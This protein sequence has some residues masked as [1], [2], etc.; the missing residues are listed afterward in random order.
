M[1]NCN[2]GHSTHTD[3]NH[4]CW[5]RGRGQS[6][7]GIWTWHG[8]RRGS[9]QTRSDEPRQT[10]RRT[11]ALVSWV[12]ATLRSIIFNSLS[13]HLME[14]QVVNGGRGVEDRSICGHDQDKPLQ[15]L[16]R[17]QRRR[18]VI[19]QRRQATFKS[20]SVICLPFAFE[21]ADPLQ[22]RCCWI[23]KLSSHWH[24]RKTQILNSS[25]M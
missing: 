6:A 24:Y 9:D 4:Q 20:H 16:Q 14:T 15:G 21:A 18:P 11:F 10:V 5:T 19:T 12:W 17:T 7:T 1:C 25:S 23:V 3:T 13:V 22:R 2:E 8:P